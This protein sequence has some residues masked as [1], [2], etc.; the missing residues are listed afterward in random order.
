MTT[1][2]QCNTW[3]FTRKWLSQYVYSS[4]HRSLINVRIKFSTSDYSS[5]NVLLAW[6]ILKGSIVIW[7]FS[8]I[9]KVEQADSPYWN[10]IWWCIRL[11]NHIPN[12]KC[13]SSVV[14]YA[15]KR[16]GNTEELIWFV[17]VNIHNF[18][19]PE[20][21]QSNPS[22]QAG[23]AEAGCTDCTHLGSEYLH[24]W[25]HHSLSRQSVPISV[26]IPIASSC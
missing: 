14:S 25:R 11:F 21:I 26:E 20:I 1:T 4:I 13:K 19:A 16:K 22:A 12:F 8:Y 15:M 6:F 23:S 2:R 9:S 3:T 18:F 7:Y 10:E 24:R 5:F 17:S